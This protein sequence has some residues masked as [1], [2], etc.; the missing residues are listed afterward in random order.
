MGKTLCQCT[1]D[2]FNTWE[3]ELG[4]EGFFRSDCPTNDC[5]KC[6]KFYMG[7]PRSN[8]STSI[9]DAWLIVEKF[10]LLRDYLLYEHEEGWIIQDHSERKY[11]EGD[12][13]PHAICLA[14]LKAHG[15][16]AKS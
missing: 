8:Y 9:A 12:T 16:D 14:A 15:Y 5:T 3:E 4:L 1:N 13:A 2:D 6:G 10:K 11:C 7:G